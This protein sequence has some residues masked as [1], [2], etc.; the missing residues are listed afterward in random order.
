MGYEM[1]FTPIKIGSME[2]KNRF[3]VPAMGTNLAEHNGEAGDALIAYYTGRAGN[4]RR[5]QNLL[6]SRITW[7]CFPAAMAELDCNF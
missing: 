1:M 5:C 7:L 4:F 2:V 6:A 3:V